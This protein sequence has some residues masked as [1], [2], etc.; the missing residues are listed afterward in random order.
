MKRKG[1]WVQAQYLGA[2]AKAFEVNPSARGPPVAHSSRQSD[3]PSL[4]GAPK[5]ASDPLQVQPVQ[6][7]PCASDMCCSAALCGMELL[8]GCVPLCEETL[9]RGIPSVA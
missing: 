6:I 7:G 1:F 2:H 9:C 8:L 4:T 5:Q 3:L